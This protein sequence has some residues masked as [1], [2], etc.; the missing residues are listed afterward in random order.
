MISVA[1]SDSNQTGNE[2]ISLSNSS[3]ISL[4][5][6]NPGDSIQ[7]AIEESEPGSIIEVHGG[8]Y[9]ENINISKRISIRGIYDGDGLPVINAQDNGSVITVSI[10]GVRLE[11]LTINGSVFS[12]AK[13][14]VTLSNCT[15]K[16]VSAKNN[17]YEIEFVSSNNSILYRNNLSDKSQDIRLLSSHNNSLLENDIFENGLDLFESENNTIFGDNLSN[18]SERITLNSSGSNRLS[19]NITYPIE[20]F[21]RE[22]NNST[23]NYGTIEAKDATGWTNRSG[24]R[25][26]DWEYESLTSGK[27]LDITNDLFESERILPAGGLEGE[28][29]PCCSLSGLPSTEKLDAGWPS[30][31]TE[32]SAHDNDDKRRNKHKKPAQFA[33][34]QAENSNGEGSEEKSTQD[35]EGLT[36]LV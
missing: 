11:N 3:N 4:I 19:R 20:Y 25:R 34:N 27:S 13:V 18:N 6:V 28:W 22:G 9:R 7:D 10:D 2:T 26:Y 31:A 12:D 1:S 15:I 16:N 5:V 32:K 23:V 33:S 17:H 24:A 30:F 8:V 29:L 14:N 21:S 35:A 36:E